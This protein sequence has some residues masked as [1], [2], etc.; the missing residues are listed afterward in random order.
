MEGSP[1]IH[2]LT[3]KYAIHA[4]GGGETRSAKVLAAGSFLGSGKSVFADNCNFAAV[5]KRNVPNAI[6]CANLFC[7][8]LAI[9]KTF[10]NDLIWAAYLVGIAALLDF[11]DGMLARILRVSSPIGKDLDSLAD[12]VSFGVVPGL[13]LFKFMLFTGNETSLTDIFFG[14]KE[15]NDS[16]LPYFALIIPLCSAI[17]LARFNNDIRQSDSFIGL[18]TPANAIFFSGIVLA[19]SKMLSG[20]GAGFSMGDLAMMLEH[21][22]SLNYTLLA[23]IFIFS[24]LLLAPLPLFALKFTS[25]SWKGNE[26]RYVFLIWSALLLIFLQLPAIPLVIVSYILFSVVYNLTVKKNT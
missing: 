9:I 25:F 21:R 16:L 4:S 24:F 26:I 22:D 2:E 1:E 8:C 14:K 7:G 13:M 6:T 20:E 17:R 12:I 11:F 19:L 18:P 23:F 5:I 15:E 3:R 10:E